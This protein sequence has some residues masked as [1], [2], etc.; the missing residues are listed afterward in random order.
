MMQTFLCPLPKH[1]V[2]FFPK[3]LVFQL[4][5]KVSPFT[6]QTNEVYSIFKNNIHLAA[7][8]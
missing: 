7:Y 5:L 4:L 2:S 1:P 6:L 8:H 3:Q